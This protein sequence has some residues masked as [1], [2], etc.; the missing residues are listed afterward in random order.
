MSV[1]LAFDSTMR[2]IDASG[3][4]HIA[5]SHITKACVNP[6]Y[7]RE[8][9]NSE[10]LG[11]IQ[12]KI[13]YMLRSPVELERAVP[14]FAR[15]QILSKHIPLLEI[16]RMSQ[17]EIKKFVVGAIGSDIE[18]LSPYVDADVS[19]WDEIA[20]RG[21]EDETQREFSCAYR[22][23]PIMTTGEFEGVKFDGIMTQIEADHMALVKD[24]RVGSEAIAADSQ[25]ERIPMKRT[26]LGNALIVAMTTAFPKLKIAMD[27]KTTEFLEFEKVVGVATRKTFDKAAAGKLALAMDAEMPSAPA[28]AV[29]D[30]LVDVEDPEPSK[31][32]KKNAEDAEADHPKG[33]MCS[34]C[35]MGRDA[36]PEE[37][38]EEKKKREKKEAKDAKAAKDGEPMTK[39]ESKAAMDSMAAQM[40]ADFAAAN[41]AR[42]EVRPVVGDVIALDSA[43]AI[44]GFA[45]DEMKVEH[46]D[47]TGVP[48]IR[49]VFKAAMT[50]RASSPA[51]LVAMDAA[52]FD[53]RFPNVSRIRVC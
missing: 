45:L 33:C 40:R 21:I 12:D 36:E 25:L 24:G 14:T 2:T 49:A 5:R 1:K 28:T 13:Y 37:S 48:A 10:A 3:R 15:I 41:E 16:K 7:G 9:P 42:R 43:E 23:V 20:I 38:E 32:E 19:I 39:G 46:K 26:K 4:M 51:P 44:Y 29:M 47:V 8:I 35:K 18:W 6:Y 50:N 31:K 22:Y 27:S 52:A 11:L 53:K 17:E 30:A 34:D